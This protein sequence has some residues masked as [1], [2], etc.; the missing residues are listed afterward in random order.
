MHRSQVSQAYQAADGQVGAQEEEEKK[1]KKK[2]DGDR[3]A[4]RTIL[5]MAERGHAGADDVRHASRLLL[6]R[7]SANFLAASRW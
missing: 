7:P 1:K 4:T 5:A 3:N 6:A 2:A